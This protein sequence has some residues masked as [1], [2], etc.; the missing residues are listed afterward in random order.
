MDVA[1]A[2]LWAALHLAGIRSGRISESVTVV[3][4]PGRAGAPAAVTT[5]TTADLEASPAAT[6]DDAL[7]SVPGFSLFRRTSSRVANPTTQGVTLRGLAAS[8]ASRA[9]VLADDA[10]LNDPFGGWV[11]WNRV[12]VEAVRDVSVAR[13]AA[14][15]QFGSDA[16]AGVV[17]IRTRSAG[18]GRLLADGGSHRTGRVSAWGAAPIGQSML[19]GGAEGFSTN[20]YL[21]VAPESAGAIDEPA[22]SRHASA[23][24]SLR[25]PAASLTG[26][27]L[28]ESRAN[29]TALQRNATRVSQVSASTF[30]GTRRGGWSANG[31]VAAQRYEQ[32]FSAVTAGRAS[33][34]LTSE[35]LVDAEALG[36]RGLGWWDAG[37][38]PWY[39]SVGVSA[40]RVAADLRE[41][42][43]S[44]AGASPTDRAVSQRG[45]G[46]AGEASYRG[47]RAFGGAIVRAENWSTAGNRHTVL[48]P[49][50][51]LTVPF[52]RLSVNAS[53]QSGF[54]AP[55]LN[56]LY[57]P[58]RVGSVL[59]NANALL[60]PERARGF[61]VGFV[62]RL[63]RLTGRIL[64]F[65]TDVD[66]AIV[67]VTLDTSGG[68]I[69]RQ[70]QNAARI[71]AAGAE[72]EAEL[73][74]S[75]NL[76][77]SG[78]TAYT[79]SDFVA[80]PLDAL[81]VPQV[82]RRHHAVSARGSAVGF[83]GTVTWRHVGSQYDDDLNLFRLAASS[84][85]DARAGWRVNRQ[86]ELFGAVENALDAEQEVGRTPLRTLGLPRTTRAGVRVI[87]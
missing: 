57:R 28:R 14:G 33:E 19:S 38:S 83:N 16:L 44:A 70:R 78:S 53:Y 58:F 69:L 20:G 73:Q 36:F 60:E 42:T 82:A 80:G 29:G 39:F 43:F 85:V 24:G 40:N 46:L 27:H 17:R 6:L 68:Q 56:E 75:R 61:E 77:L 84:T 35:Q 37:D 74:V 87:F 67:N 64:G 81:A 62:A 21:T 48:S 1:S 8:G 31:H 15:D 22:A 52:E 10:P 13:G 5:L 49:R 55:T 12:P 86:V 54:R 45:L 76:T 72:I 30:R 41:T 50:I 25:I 11:Y 71:R 3:A 63:A 23:Y 2:L 47:A 66:D 59:T 26:S 9:L 4:Q 79:R 65:R 18:G 32:T 7:R 51:W 34:R